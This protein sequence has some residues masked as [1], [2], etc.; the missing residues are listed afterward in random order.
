MQMQVELLLWDGPRGGQAETLLMV[1][2][3]SGVWTAMVGRLSTSTT[4]AVRCRT[5]TQL[6]WF[7][8]N[9]DWTGALHQPQLSCSGCAV[10][11]P[12][13]TSVACHT[14]SHFSMIPPNL[15]STLHTTNP[16]KESMAPTT[17]A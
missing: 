3:T 13:A 11:Q 10:L 7:L 1:E 9:G 6:E 12:L 4:F 16:R 14:Q 2:G 8:A 17:F 15:S 5:R